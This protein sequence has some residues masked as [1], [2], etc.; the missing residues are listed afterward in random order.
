MDAPA[1]GTE[2]AGW[3]RSTPRWAL[4]PKAVP[5][6]R[7]DIG[8]LTHEQR[9]MPRYTAGVTNIGDNV[10]GTCECCK[11]WN[12]RLYPWGETDRLCAHCHHYVSRIFQR[13]GAR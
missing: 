1:A 2:P 5:A 8:G 13:V 9:V 6:T 4:H 3:A 12:F 10:A 7:A 11:R